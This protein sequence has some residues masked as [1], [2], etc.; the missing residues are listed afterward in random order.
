MRRTK[1]YMRLVEPGKK[2]DTTVSDKLRRY[3]NQYVEKIQAT[4]DAGTSADDA[5]K[6]IK[7][8]VSRL[9]PDDLIALLWENQHLGT[10]DIP[11]GSVNLLYA[12]EG[13]LQKAIYTAAVQWWGKQETKQ[14]RQTNPGDKTVVT[15]PKD[16]TQDD[17]GTKVE[18][19]AKAAAVK[20]NAMRTIRYQ[21]RVYRLADSYDAEQFTRFDQIILLRRSVAEWNAWYQQHSEK[22]D[23]RGARLQSI[24]LQAADLQGVG[25]QEADLRSANLYETN[26][27][28]ADLSKANLQEAFLFNT[29]LQGTDLCGANLLG[30]RMENLALYNIN[31]RGANLGGASLE[32]VDLQGADLRDVNLRMAVLTN[33]NLKAANMKKTNLLHTNLQTADLRGAKLQKAQYNRATRFPVG[34]DPEAQGMIL[35]G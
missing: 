5:F 23:L 14:R 31:L 20:G 35:V 6:K 13:I 22:V 7:P 26:L 15:K 1:A 19:P 2:V 16:T 8:D 11:K 32:N 3:V 30:A 25:L 9:A 33:V 18:T 21:G 34:F 17:V 24:D 29:K 12:L 28:G 4:I 10:W 27:Q